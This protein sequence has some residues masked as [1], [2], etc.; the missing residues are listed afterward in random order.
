M[1]LRKEGFPEEDDIVLCTVT[2]VQPHSV[3]VTLDEYGGRTAM[4]HISEIAPGRIRNIRDFVQEGKKV[5][6]KVLQINREK[7]Y[8]DLSLRRVNASQRRDKNDEIKQ[9]GL[10]EKIIENVSRE[11]KIDVKVLYAEIIKKLETDTL[12]PSFEAVSK[13]ELSLEEKGIDKK[14]ADSIKTIILQR[15]KAPEVVV[16]GTFSLSSYA[17]DGVQIIKKALALITEGKVSYLGAG[18][19]RY[20]IKSDD[21]KK[22]EKVLKA[23]VEAIMDFAKVHGLHAEFVRKNE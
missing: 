12:F 1:F 20:N 23:T 13:D 2:G 3:F 10:C 18:A 8:I 16:E 7:G 22:A 4:I 15:I 11:Q 5:V 9:E 14:I 6:C 19:F 21:Y 17:P